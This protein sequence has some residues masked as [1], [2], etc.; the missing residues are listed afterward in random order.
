MRAAHLRNMLSVAWLWTALGCRST[1]AQTAPFATPLQARLS[2]PLD[3]RLSQAGT[4]VSAVALVEWHGPDCLLKVGRALS[5]H[6]L[7]AQ[8]FQESQKEASLTVLFNR[9]DCNDGKSVPVSLVLFAV[10]SNSV[11]TRDAPLQYDSTG[12]LKA[13]GPKDGVTPLVGLVS[14]P[15]G[16]STGASAQGAINFSPIPPQPALPDSIKAGDVFGF[17]K[18]KLSPGTGPAGASIVHV[19]KH[20]FIIP[21][22]TQLV[23][24]SFQTTTTEPGLA[25]NPGLNDRKQPGKLK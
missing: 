16:R 10:I 17:G 4:P 20:D 23:L 14:T 22:R 6:V 18:L 24:V 7:K 1:P 21:A 15:Y 13:P 12:L 19:A 5:G 3:S 8:P 9:A 25:A 2:V 11:A